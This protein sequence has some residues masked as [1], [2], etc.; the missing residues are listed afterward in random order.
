M[1]FKKRLKTTPKYINT[2][3]ERHIANQRDFF[4]YFPRDHEDRTSIKTISELQEWV[5]S[6]LKAK[7]VDKNLI[8]TP[9]WKKIIEFKLQ[10]EQGNLAYAS[11]MNA[12]FMLRTLQKWNNILLSWK[13]KFSYWKYTFWFP[14]I[15]SNNFN[16]EIVSSNLVWNIVPIY[17]DLSWIKWSWFQKKMSEKID[18]IENC[19]EEF[20]PKYLL[21][22]Y[23]LLPI[24]AALHNIHFPKNSQTLQKAQYRFYFE[25][26][27][28]WQLIANA[29]L[30][31]QE[32]KPASKP[33]RS[34]ISNFLSKLPFELTLA[35][36]KAIKIIIEDIHSWKIMTR[37]L[38]WDVWSWKTVVSAIVSFYMISKFKK[39]VAFLAPTEVLASQHA[40]SLSK[41]LLPLWIKMS[42]LTWS[43]NKKDKEQIKQNL[44][45]KNIDFLVWTHAI[46]QDD[47]IFKDLWLVI[48]DEQHKFGV[49]QRSKLTSQ[50]N[51]HMLQMTATP[52]PR[53]LALSYF[54]EFENTIIDELPPWRQTIQ[55]KVIDENEYEKLKQ[56]LISKINQNQQVYVVAPLIEESDKIE[57]VNSAF[58]EYEKLKNMFS[59]LSENEIWLMH[60]RLKSEEKNKIMQ[61][62]QR[63]KIKILVSTTVIEVGVDVPTATVMIIKNSERFGLSS[64]HQ[65]RWRVGRGNRQ[66]YCFLVTKNKSWESYKRVKYMEE[67]SDGF[68]LAEIDLNLRWAWTILGTQQSGE[69]DLPQQALKDIELLENS[70][71]EAKYILENWILKKEPKL[72]ALVDQKI[73]FSKLIS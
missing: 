13:P 1:D 18:E 55:T 3:A 16:D 58:E 19:V 42:L 29:N 53:S 34:I 20:L 68:K 28:I 33:D 73:N 21:K 26:L 50:W 69:M 56:F 63:W 66:S 71:N 46:I 62:F 35:Q 61:D 23:D 72:K 30:E 41:T 70:R 11:F 4:Y 7:I 9:R 59:E 47:V 2:L 17:S 14:E 5:K 57:D 65:L 54:G 22:K 60:G 24:H 36:K 32:K 31:N 25:Q 27:L 44:Q 40:K 10:D 6:V 43:S 52:I 8:N 38:Q 64:L 45:E 51:P 48:I 12:T 39:Q 37:L 49:N 67:Y 15:L